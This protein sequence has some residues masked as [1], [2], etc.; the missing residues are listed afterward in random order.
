[1]DIELNV[2]PKVRIL[3][4]FLR[5]S[6]GS[7]GG[8]GESA[9]VSSSRSSSSSS[10]DDDD[11][12]D[13]DAVAQLVTAN[14]S[15]LAYSREKFGRLLYQMAREDA[16]AQ[17]DAKATRGAQRVG[18][19]RTDIDRTLKGDKSLGAWLER[20]RV[21]RNDYAEWLEG[22]LRGTCGGKAPSSS[23]SS[24]SSNAQSGPPG[25]SRARHPLRR[26]RAVREVS[27]PVLVKLEK[28]HGV[29][30]AEIEAKLARRSDGGT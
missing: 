23:S 17:E 12:D 26:A 9:D 3:R 4:E 22:R 6:G 15:Y 30:L 7:G 20:V 24:G 25:V 2:A 10:D 8:G 29:K 19:V 1:M 27:D 28:S 13:D 5:R 21:P 16:A 14:P 18:L 11:D